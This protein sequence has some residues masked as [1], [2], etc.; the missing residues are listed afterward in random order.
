MGSLFQ[1]RA[2]DLAE[3]RG[4]ILATKAAPREVRNAINREMRANLN[5]IWRESIKAKM[6]GLPDVDRTIL[7][8]G[9][10][11][12]AGNSAQLIAGNSTKALSGGLVPNRWAKSWEFGTYDREKKKTYTRRN[13]RNSGTHTVSRR[14]RRQLPAL[15]RQGHAIWPSAA[16]SIPRVISLQVQTVVRA[17]NEMLGN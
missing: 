11:V 2:A 4:I 9:A 6:A 1:V 12:K 3:L 16:E 10:R 14:T 7:G 15:A 8:K 5:P 13:R 17:L